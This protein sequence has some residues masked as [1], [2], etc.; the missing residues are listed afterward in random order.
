MFFSRGFY[1]VLFTRIKKKKIF[2][3]ILMNVER[4]LECVKMASV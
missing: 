2:L 1:E 3:Q 4:F